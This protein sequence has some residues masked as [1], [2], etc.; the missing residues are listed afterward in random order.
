MITGRW[1]MVDIPC[2]ISFIF[3]L[4]LTTHSPRGCSLAS[5]KPSRLWFQRHNHHWLLIPCHCRYHWLHSPLVARSQLNTMVVSTTKPA[6]SFHVLRHRYSPKS[7]GSGLATG[8]H[9]ASCGGST[10]CKVDS[11]A[12]DRWVINVTTC[13]NQLVVLCIFGMVGWCWL[14]N[15]D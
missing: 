4:S 12:L 14:V 10:G 5:E 7:T 9:A 3:R 13:Y 1:W 11:G 2:I 15:V 8:S 6:L